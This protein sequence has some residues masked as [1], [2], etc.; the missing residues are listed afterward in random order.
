[1]RYLTFRAIS[2]VAFWRQG[3]ISSSNTLHNAKTLSQPMFDDKITVTP[4]GGRLSTKPKCSGTLL[5][6]L[7]WSVFSAGDVSN[8]RTF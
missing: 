5:N 4:A 7:K 1:M 2:L 8:P 6:C 3:Q